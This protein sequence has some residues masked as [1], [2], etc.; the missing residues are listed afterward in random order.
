MSGFGLLNLGTQ[1]LQANQTALSVTGQNISNVNTDGY[2]RQ[3]PVFQAREELGGVKIDDIDRIA[4]AFLNRQI[5][6]DSASYNSY[7]EYKEYANELDNLMA[8]NI[9]SIST[10]MDDYFGAL[11]TAV[12]DPVSLPNRELF[13]A[14]SDA[15][16]K[17]FNDL[18]ANI[19]RQ[20]DT[21]NGRLESNVS[22]IN[23]IATHIATLNDDIRI[24]EAAGGAS[25][26]LLDQ[27]DAKLE[28]LSEYISFTTLDQ[29][30][31]EVSVFIGNGEPLVVGLSANSLTTIASPADTSQLNVA[32]QIG[33][34]VADITNQV[35]GGKV[36]G[37]LDYRENIL[38]NTLDELG[39][40][41]LVFA[42]TMNEQHVKGIDLD[43]NAG[44]LMF[45]D[46]NS[47]AAS[48]SRVLSERDNTSSISASVT[49]NDV[50]ALQAAEYELIFND[51]DTFTLIRGD[52]ETVWSSDTLT[53]E[54][55]ATDVDQ[56]GEYFFNQSTGELRI[57]ID[58][59]TLNMDA[60]PS[61][62]TG[63]KY[64]I[65]PTRNGAAELTSILNNA[66]QLALASP[67]TV[68]ESVS[69][70][71]TGTATVSIT[72][73][74]YEA[75]SA[76]PTTTTPPTVA[77]LVVN[78][79]VSNGGDVAI[80]MTDET[81]VNNL[82][83]PLTLT[84]NASGDY[85]ISDSDG[86]LA[87]SPYTPVGGVI[88]LTAAF[89]LS[90]T[91]SGTPVAG[92][93]TQ[94]EYDATSIPD[95]SL[96][97]PLNVSFLPAFEG[98]AN[99]GNKIVTIPA[100]L[101]GTD[102][103]T[104]IDFST[105]TVGFTDAELAGQEVY[106]LTFT[107]NGAGSFVVTDVNSNV[108]DTVAAAT[109]MDISSL[110]LTISVAS[111]PGGLVSGNAFT[112]QPD[113]D[114]QV[115]YS[116]VF[117]PVTT[118]SGTLEGR[119]TDPSLVTG[120]EFPL[121]VEQVSLGNYEV[122]DSL[123]ASLY[124]GALDVDNNLSLSA[125]GLNINVSTPPTV[126]DVV[127]IQPDTNSNGNA[128]AAVTNIRITDDRLVGAVSYPLT[129][130]YDTATS[131]FTVSDSESPAEVLF[132]GAWDS[133]TLD[134]TNT[135]GFAIDLNST[136]TPADGDTFIIQHDA[137]SDAA[138]FV[139]LR[140]AD[141]DRVLKEYTPGQ[142]IQLSGYEVTIS[143]QPKV[144]DRFTVNPNID[145]VS[146][147]RNALLM[148]DLQFAKIV[149]G[150]SYQDKYGQTVERVGTQAAVAQVNASAGKAVLDANIEK[151]D[152]ISG[153][154]LDEEAAKLV[155]FQQAY[156]ASAQLI[157]AAQTI[158]DSL[159]QSL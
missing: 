19:R 136:Q 13:I 148:S 138:E 56:D 114:N 127:T 45:Q 69:N 89:G 24:S 47:G 44:G 31:G 80:Q 59:F 107:H 152:S 132:R 2:S 10:A 95:S 126:G 111:I 4:D 131:E 159:L 60:T 41:A 139:V 34:N 118:P 122:R 129:V 81:R 32:L 121:S 135:Y 142:A 156:Q 109:T 82:A 28:E 38:N 14:Q 20:N 11:Q 115:Q 8:S 143:N 57:Q 147:N 144:G 124:T 49:I 3:R 123:G 150:A 76:V 55:I 98:V 110:G 137:S 71:G 46:I 119:V 12:D 154:N 149:E 15:L 5:W 7:D 103:S 61:F 125:L 58:G 134:L 40:M 50:Q 106:P 83:Y 90:L 16:V 78:A 120:I 153:V 93:V 105:A 112:I 151:R 141:G 35:S 75:L 117:S 99:T 29:G 39:R 68:S 97:P 87:G 54:T 92:E 6:A 62:S 79:D 74:E 70:T 25:S 100:S 158:F 30:T 64:L 65:H 48:A 9:T 27:R 157:R 104:G 23:T 26:E 84:Y 91:V 101:S 130:I 113:D 67:L 140:D 88:D 63:D 146:D 116:P 42:D 18:D 85:T 37:L 128:D 17:R 133:G 77:G 43:G 22:V 66:R 108:V 21:I 72:D 52:H 1:S 155:Q 94:V 53:P 96:T 102:T 33:S 36:G 86:A 73:N 51:H 145:G